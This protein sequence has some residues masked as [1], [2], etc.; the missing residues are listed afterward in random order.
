[1]HTKFT[2]EQIKE[3]RELKLLEHD[4]KKQC[5]DLDEQIKKFERQKAHQEE[6]LKELRERLSKSF[7]ELDQNEHLFRTDELPETSSQSNRRTYITQDRKTE[8]LDAA[9]EKYKAAFTD[10]DNMPFSWLKNYLEEEHD[11]HCRSVSTFF[12][13]LMDEFTLAGG[14]RNKS[15]VLESNRAD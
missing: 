3:F 12:R 15:I 13:G 6:E 10:S 9:I 5:R 2:I 8:L 14:N 11:I 1:M 4:L 7:S